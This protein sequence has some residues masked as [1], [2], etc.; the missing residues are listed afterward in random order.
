MEITRRQLMLASASL[1][2]CPRGASAHEDEVFVLPPLPYAYEAL[3]PIIDTETMKLHHDKHHATYV[4]K[5]N[6]AMAKAPSPWAEADL[7][8][9]LGSLDKLPESLR[10]PVRNNGGGHYNHSV[11]WKIM[12]KPDTTKP[13]GAL[14]Q[15]LNSR[16]GSLEKFQAVLNQA[17]TG[18]FGSGW[19]WLTMFGDGSL[20]VE[21]T[22]NQESP[23]MAGHYPLLGLDVW[24]HAYYLKYQNRRP[25]YVAAWWHV[26]D[27]NAV[28]E[29]YA[30]G[31][32]RMK[33]S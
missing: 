8:T 29:R 16:F 1:A 10:T 3:E 5:L 4:A 11:F 15:A 2:L 19:A 20:G 33:V 28:G 12:G 21:S 18:R 25:D 26:V 9:L 7:E 22:A 31:R 23:I 32:E 30:L 24:E 14:L 6:E 17:A 13:S 27:W